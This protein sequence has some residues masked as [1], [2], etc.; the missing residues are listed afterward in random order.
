MKHIKKKYLFQKELSE[1]IK[2]I[3]DKKASTVKRTSKDLI[4][5]SKE[6]DLLLRIKG[7]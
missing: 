3:L 1:D 7:F 2:D 6:L 5:I 4:K